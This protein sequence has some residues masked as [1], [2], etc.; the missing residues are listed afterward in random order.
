MLPWRG[1][2]RWV[3]GVG[4]TTTLSALHYPHNAWFAQRTGGA[5]K[6]YIE[7]AQPDL[8]KRILM[9]Q[10][11]GNMVG[12]EALREGLKVARFLMFDA[13]VP[14]E[15]ID[16]T[17][18]A[19]ETKDDAY[20]KYVRP[21]WRD[22]TN[23][24]WASNWHRLFA[25]A[26]GDVR[27]R[28]SWPNRFQNALANAGEAFNYYSSGDSVFSE[29]EA[30]P[31]LMSG[32]ITNTGVG[33]FLGFIPYP[34][35]EVVFENHCWQKQEVLKGM[36]TIAGTL[37]GGWGFNIWQEYDTQDD[38]WKDV[39]YSPLGVVHAIENGSITSRPAFDISDAAEMMSPNATEDDVFLALAKHIPALSSPVGGNAV[40]SSN[41][42]NLNDADEIERPNGW[43]RDDEFIYKQ[44]WLHSDMKDMA[45]L[46]VFKLY[47]QLTQEGVLK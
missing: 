31:S 7:A 41:N 42:I 3:E 22:Y 13:A 40:L 1:D 25:G 2:Y 45:Y 18:R 23:V 47:D 43:G 11:L 5:L 35:F 19:E 4:L 15:A 30:I 34:K 38:E 27:G 20:A 26:P 32:V 12:C 37:S 24:C 39:Y 6:R 36:T 21:E 28:M 10:S 14:S 29:M 9:T 44:K 16:G 8:S 17:L 46:F 33:F